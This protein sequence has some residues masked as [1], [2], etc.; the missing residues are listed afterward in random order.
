MDLGLLF[1]FVEFDMIINV[2]QL[3]LKG[4]SSVCLTLIDNGFNVCGIETK[5][6]N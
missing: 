3:V 4:I 5:G 1:H 2:C 6:V